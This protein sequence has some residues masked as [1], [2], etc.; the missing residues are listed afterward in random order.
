MNTAGYSQLKR[1]VA[2][3]LSQQYEPDLYPAWF[4]NITFVTWHKQLVKDAPIENIQ[5]QRVH[6]DIFFSLQDVTK[7]R[8]RK[9]IIQHYIAETPNKTLLNSTVF[10]GS[11]NSVVLCFWTA[12]KDWRVSKRWCTKGDQWVLLPPFYEWQDVMKGN[13]WVIVSSSA[14]FLGGGVAPLGS[15]E[16]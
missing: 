3:F 5:R 7:E 4:E 16:K 8:V 10:P 13:Q 14:L 12:P 15:H 9:N 6:A 1:C 2:D 11:K